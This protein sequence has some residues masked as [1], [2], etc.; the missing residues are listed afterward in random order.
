MEFR[1][2]I[3]AKKRLERF[4]LKNRVRE[5]PILEKLF[6]TATLLE[7]TKKITEAN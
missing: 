2:K 4:H 3:K 7:A 1:L 5:R 6:E